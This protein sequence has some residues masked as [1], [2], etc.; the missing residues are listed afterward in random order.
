MK[1]GCD[2][3]IFLPLPLFLTVRIQPYFLSNK[4]RPFPKEIMTS[5]S[6]QAELELDAAGLEVAEPRFW[7]Q[8]RTSGPYGE[9]KDNS[10]TNHA[11]LT[12]EASPRKSGSI[13]GLLPATFFM[14][15]A[16]IL[17]IVIAGVGGG[18][19]GTIAVNNAKK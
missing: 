19:G 11:V 12:S 10:H 18:V 3:D 5:T 8:R 6:A 9:Q 14:L 1:E 13:C 15:A 17:V 7:A 4:L 2:S 16:L